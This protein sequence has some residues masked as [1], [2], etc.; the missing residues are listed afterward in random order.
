MYVSSHGRRGFEHA[1]GVIPTRAPELQLF[2]ATARDDVHAL[3]SR[4]SKLVCIVDLV[5]I[6]SCSFSNYSHLQRQPWQ[7]ELRGK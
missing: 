7:V 3:D 6:P 5:R 1:I 2:A 4:V